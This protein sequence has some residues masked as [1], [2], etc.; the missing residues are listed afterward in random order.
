MFGKYIRLPHLL[1]IFTLFLSCAQ[2]KSPVQD[3]IVSVQ[4]HFAPDPTTAIFDIRSN[5]ESGNHILQGETDNPEAYDALKDS[6]ERLGM[7]YIDQV[8]V[9][10]EAQLGERTWALV[11]VSVANMRKTPGHASELVTQSLLGTMLKVL[12]KNESWY[13]VQTPDRY[14]GWVDGGGITNL[15][16]GEI[17]EY[18]TREKI[19][20][21]EIYG[22]SYAQPAEDAIKVSDLTSGNL[23]SLAETG[24]DYYKVLYPDGRVAYVRMTE[25]ELF[26]K[27]LD[28][29]SPDED[30]LIST[31]FELLGV[32]Y[33]W[34]GTSPKAMDCSGFT[35]TVYFLNGII[36]PRDASQQHAIGQQV[37]DKKDFHAL[38]KGDLLYFGRP[39]TDSTSERIVHVGMWIGNMEFIHASGDVHIS[40]MDPASELY[41]PY[42]NARYLCAWRLIG[43]EKIKEYSLKKIF[44]E[45]W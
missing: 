28:M 23:L 13:L 17:E 19:I 10:P 30:I 38:K 1:S 45:F 22:F 25:S 11:N 9:L 2:E 6:L 44:F 33:L 3:V 31:S 14:L 42:N 26:T 37:D 27:W 15:T 12:K 5:R 34:G 36:L 43:S 4:D 20:F 39:A 41:D 21:T 40:S 35:K 24:S 32:P 8:T 29:K 16:R 7:P 18:I